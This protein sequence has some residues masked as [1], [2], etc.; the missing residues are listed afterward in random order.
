MTEMLT[1]KE[2]QTLLQVDRSTIYRMAEAQKLPAI[3]VGKQWRFPADQIEGWLQQ[4]NSGPGPATTPAPN[5][6][7]DSLAACLPL[8]CVQLIQDTLAPALGVMIVVTDM[9]GNPS[10]EISHP[11]GLFK[12]ISQTP[13]AIQKC[14]ENWT[15][16]EAVPGLA[17]KFIHSRLGLL[18]A[19]GLVRSG[20]ELKGMAIV[21]GVAAPDWPPAP[22]QVA[23]PA[24][25]VGLR[26]QA[27]THNL[28]ADRYLDKAQKTLALVMVQ[29]MAD[30]LAHLA[31]EQGNMMGKLES[32]AGL[33]AGNN[34]SL[35]V[36]K[37]HPSQTDRA[38]INETK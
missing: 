8:G 16:L 1:A 31:T 32:M 2:M 38:F 4:K 7:G 12:V 27:V 37:H 35:L 17:P 25:V 33:A 30:I 11:C 22:Q 28:H 21:G 9:Q 14:I 34:G 18:G 36:T 23:D 19:R 24:A 13:N 6:P 3:K 29:R 5:G 20:A 26:A 15:H 10:T